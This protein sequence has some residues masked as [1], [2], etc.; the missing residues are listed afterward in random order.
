MFDDLLCALPGVSGLIATVAHGIIRKLDTSVE[1]PGP[2]SFIVRMESLACDT[3]R[4]SHPAPRVVTIA[5]RPR[6]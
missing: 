4:P 1:V 2:H 3:K 5:I 6:E